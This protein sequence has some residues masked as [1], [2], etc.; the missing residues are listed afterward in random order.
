VAHLDIVC[1]LLSQINSLMKASL[2]AYQR[3]VDVLESQ[4]LHLWHYIFYNC[5][6]PVQDNGSS[7]SGWECNKRRIEEN[8]TVPVD[9]AGIPPPN[10]TQGLI[11]VT[12]EVLNGGCIMGRVR[13]GQANTS[14]APT[15]TMPMPGLEQPDLL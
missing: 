10:N 3:A 8:S 14:P 12:A 9:E 4:A 15:N 7:L 1:T 11:L 2:N 5:N 6:D 13:V